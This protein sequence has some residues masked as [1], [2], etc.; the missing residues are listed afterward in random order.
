V[1]YCG[2]C[3]DET[4]RWE[5]RTFAITDTCEKCGKRLIRNE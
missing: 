3:Y 5:G 1:S 4:K 2:E